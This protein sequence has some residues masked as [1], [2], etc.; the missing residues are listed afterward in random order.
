M[1][2]LR[3]VFSDTSRMGSL[4]DRFTD[5]LH[6]EF[7]RDTFTA[8]LQTEYAKRC[9]CWQLWYPLQKCNN[10]N[11]LKIK[12]FLPET[13]VILS[14]YVRVTSWHHNRITDLIIGGA[15][16][17]SCKLPRYACDWRRPVRYNGKRCTDRVH[18]G[19]T[20]SSTESRSRKNIQVYLVN[21]SNFHL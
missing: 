16:V 6:T 21:Y 10:R 3:K 13:D 9:F 5:N 18:A 19:L 14:V 11:G 4:K 17:V 1:E 7:A 15:I 12:I 8:I 20:S 2:N